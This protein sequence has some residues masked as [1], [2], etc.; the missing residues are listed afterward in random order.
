[1]NDQ[2]KEWVKAEAFGNQRPKESWRKRTRF[3][4][5][6]DIL[7]DKRMENGTARLCGLIYSR[8]SNGKTKA[9]IPRKWLMAHCGWSNKEV[10]YKHRKLLIE[11]GWIS[12]TVRIAKGT[13]E[14]SQYEFYE[15]CDGPF[16]VPET[17]P[18]VGPETGTMDTSD[19]TYLLKEEAKRHKA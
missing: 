14:A 12:V 1:M 11:L 19:T 4:V 17:G 9:Q 10:F 7:R 5:M 13:V 6:F 8:M 3:N 18:G 2:F 16:R 15:R